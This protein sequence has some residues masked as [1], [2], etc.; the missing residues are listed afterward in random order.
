MQVAAC[1]RLVS[2][3]DS[4]QQQQE[5]DHAKRVPDGHGRSFGSSPWQKDQTMCFYLILLTKNTKAFFFKFIFE[6]LF[7]FIYVYKNQSLIKINQHF[8]KYVLIWVKKM[9]I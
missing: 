6:K 4:Q 8:L 1:F 2:L 3:L 7:F 5:E 9:I